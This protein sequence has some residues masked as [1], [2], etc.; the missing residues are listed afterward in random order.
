VEACRA[1][2]AGCFEL[3]LEPGH[4]GAMAGNVEPLM[5]SLL[6]SMHACAEAPEMRHGIARILRWSYETL[7]PLEQL[8]P[9][10]ER[11]WQEIPGESE[12]AA[13]ATPVVGVPPL[14]FPAM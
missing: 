5:L 12:T 9:A 7:L 3:G 1:Y 10:L 14:L 6:S 4:A 13:R 11:Y 2:I 8:A